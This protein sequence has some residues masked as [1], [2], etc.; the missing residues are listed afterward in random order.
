[1]SLNCCLFTDSNNTHNACDEQAT[2]Q[3]IQTDH[4]EDVEA[5]R[6][7]TNRHAHHRRRAQHGKEGVREEEDGVGAAVVIIRQTLQHNNYSLI[8]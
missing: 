3:C 5:V 6:F 1:M 2:E 4:F 7:A 8:Y